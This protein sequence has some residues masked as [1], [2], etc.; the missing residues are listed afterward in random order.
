MRVGLLMVACGVA[1]GVLPGE[2]LLFSL[3]AWSHDDHIWLLLGLSESR[4][5]FLAHTTVTKVRALL[6]DVKP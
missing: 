6:A 5:K 1:F 3:S 4:R 2:G